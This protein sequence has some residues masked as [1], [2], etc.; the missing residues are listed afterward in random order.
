MPCADC[1]ASISRRAEYCP[2]CGG[3][4]NETSENGEGDEDDDDAVSLTVD[5]K[6]WLTTIALGILLSSVIVAAVFY[7]IALVSLVYSSLAQR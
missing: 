1:G 2:H 3:P 6:G 4:T 7:L 5:R